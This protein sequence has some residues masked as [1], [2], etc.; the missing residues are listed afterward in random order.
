MDNRHARLSQPFK[1]AQNATTCDN[2]LARLLATTSKFPYRWKLM[3]V[4]SMIITVCYG[5]VYP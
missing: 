4:I 2:L 5:I 1:V 3:F